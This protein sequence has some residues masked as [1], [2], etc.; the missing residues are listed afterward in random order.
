MASESAIAEGSTVV[1][2]DEINFHQK[3]Y[4]H[5]SYNYNAQNPNNFGQPITLGV[6]QTPITINIPPDC[7]N[8]GLAKLNYTTVL[9]AGANYIWYH[10]QALR[11]ISHIQYHTQNGVYMVDLD[12]VQNYLDITIKRETERDEF[13]TMDP[14]LNEVGINNSPVNVV[15]ALRN[16]NV[17]NVNTDNRPLNPSSVNYMEPAY[18][19]VSGYQQEVRYNVSF[20][21]R[22]LK[23]TWFSCEKE[24]YCPVSTYLKI[25]FGPLDKV[26]YNSTSNASPS[27]GIKTPYTVGAAAPPVNVIPRIENLQ[28]ML[29][30]ETNDNI[31]AT[32]KAKVETSGLSYIIPFVVAYKNPNQSSPQ[33]IQL[34]FNGQL[35]RTLEKVYHAVYNNQE[36][37]DTAYDHSNNEVV[38]GVLDSVTNQ[39]VRSYY[40][41]LNTVR[42]Q[43]LTLDCTSTGPYLDYMQNREYFRK[44]VLS[45]LNVYHYNWHHVDDFCRFGADYDQNSKGELVSGIEL[46]GKD[47]MW[48]FYGQTMKNTAFQHYTWAVFSRKM[49][50]DPTGQFM[51]GQPM[52][53]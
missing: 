20:P 53:V 10:R 26:C 6:S 16:A 30:I 42:I 5:P 8:I 44:S 36:Q 49:I 28:L 41:T 2:S 7:Y 46:G 52:I 12:N 17:N 39:K 23:N 32:L 33:S 11:E 3:L 31:R 15:P 22:L 1:S 29:P 40:T 38:A 37:L 50:I 51:V 13:I 24:I 43:N 25:Y 14:F 27:A 34:V 48:G 47:I 45:N 18:F 19:D 21:L 35:G 9:P 4:S